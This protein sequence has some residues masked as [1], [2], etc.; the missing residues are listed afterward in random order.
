[1]V[2][3]QRSFLFLLLLG[4]GYVI[5]LWHSLGLPYNNFMQLKI[6]INFISDKTMQ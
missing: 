6:F 1:M 3:V 2:S 4:I 5:S